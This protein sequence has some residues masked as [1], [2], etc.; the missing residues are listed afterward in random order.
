MRRKYKNLIWRL[1]LTKE[2]LGIEA[3]EVIKELLEENEKLHEGYD[4]MLRELQK[5]HRARV[6]E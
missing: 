3:A 1:E 4:S 6:E 2:P 5:E